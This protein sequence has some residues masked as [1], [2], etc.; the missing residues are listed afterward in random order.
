VTVS[1]DARPAPEWTE[2]VGRT[3]DEAIREGLG[4]L[5]LSSVEQAE[6]EVID[7]PQRGLLGVL[8]GREARVRLRPRSDKA[9]EI[10]HLVRDILQTL[11]LAG[12]SVEVV[13]GEGGYIHVDVRGPGLGRLIGRRGETL[14]ALQYLLNLAS[15]RIPGPAERVIFDADGY[16]ERRRAALERLVSRVAGRVRRTNRE[17][18]LEPMTPQERKVV[19]LAVGRE[20]GITSESCGEEPYRRVVIRPDRPG[21][22]D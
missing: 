10:E 21:E 13:R 2:T 7:E 16:R 22:E 18:V 5:G 6:V 17:V 12:T 1:R 19:H 14:D 15:A 3:V 4:R 20:E 8:G 11:Q 9:R